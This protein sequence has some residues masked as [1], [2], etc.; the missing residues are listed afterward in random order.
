MQSPSVMLPLGALLLWADSLPHCTGSFVPAHHAETSQILV[1]TKYRRPPRFHWFSPNFSSQYLCSQVSYQKL[2]KAKN[3]HHHCPKS[4]FL[5]MIS[6]QRLSQRSAAWPLSC[7][8]WG[9]GAWGGRKGGGGCAIVLITSRWGRAMS[10]HAP[11]LFLA[12]NPPS[13]TFPPGLSFTFL[14]AA[15]ES[16]RSIWSEQA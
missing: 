2:V 4:V 5:H 6:T 14:L 12:L 3:N 10:K 7:P 13:V 11:H 9:M 15:C 1:L 8:K 16:F